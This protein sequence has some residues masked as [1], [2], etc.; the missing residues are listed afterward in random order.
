MG[1]FREDIFS[2][3]D[4]PYEFDMLLFYVKEQIPI[5]YHWD[6]ID[7]KYKNTFETLA[8]HLTGGSAEDTLHQL[9]DNM[10]MDEHIFLLGIPEP[11]CTKEQLLKRVEEIEEQEK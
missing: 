2:K 5:M 4:K 7:Y 3:P 10:K 1:T 6:I 9:I 8:Q 11:I